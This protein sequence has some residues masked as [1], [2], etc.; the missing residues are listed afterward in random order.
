MSEL[1]VFHYSGRIFTAVYRLGE[2][3]FVIF[4]GF[5][6]AGTALASFHG[7]EGNYALRSAVFHHRR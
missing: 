5:C 7:L 1:A 4:A 3:R 2:G 6:D